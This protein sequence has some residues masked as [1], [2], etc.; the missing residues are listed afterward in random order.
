[1]LVFKNAKIQVAPNAKPKICVT[2]NAK[3][4]RELVEYRF[5]LWGSRW[6]CAFQVVCVNFICV[7]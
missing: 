3:P 1:M 6:A 7:W 2:P 5:W 4:Q